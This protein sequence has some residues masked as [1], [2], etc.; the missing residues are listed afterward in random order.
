MHELHRP[1]VIY[2]QKKVNLIEVEALYIASR[3]PRF[4]YSGTRFATYPPAAILRRKIVHRQKREQKL[5][6]AIV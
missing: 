1:Q 2:P 3:P 6:D 4:N 5:C